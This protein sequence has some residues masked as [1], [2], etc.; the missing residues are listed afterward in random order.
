MNLFNRMIALALPLVPKPM[1]GYF[2]RR[3]I[4]GSRLVDMVGEVK[5]LN[6]MGMCATIDVLGESIRNLDEAQAPLKQY[7]QALDIIELEKLDANISVKP[8]QM[9]LMIDYEACRANFAR[10]LKSAAAKGNFVRIDMEDATTTNAALKLY[11]DLRENFDNVGI[12][13]QAHLR[14]TLSDIQN[15]SRKVDSL[16]FRICKGIYIEPRKIAWKDRRIIQLNFELLLEEAFE[17]GAYAGI[18]THDELLVW[19]AL[20]VIHKMKIPKNR[21]EFQMLLG[22]QPGLRK[23]IV[24]AGHKLRVYVPFGKD[25]Y[26]YSVR[27]LR[28]NPQIAGHIV[29]ALFT[30]PVR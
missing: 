15:L 1:V 6:E 19:A 18:A 5:R 26:P 17:K 25:W 12:V 9:G 23:I 30:P 14:R 3:Y 2:S 11:T 28:E 4:A 16:N 20:K 27:R 21:Y 24:D 10:L 22:V 29:K 8:T 13:L 7:L